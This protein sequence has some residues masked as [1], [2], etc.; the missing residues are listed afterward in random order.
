MSHLLSFARNR[1]HVKRLNHT[2]IEK[3]HGETENDSVHATIEL[4]THQTA[5]TSKQQYIVKEMSAGEFIDL[6]DNGE[7]VIWSKVRQVTAR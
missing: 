2:F 5:R 4:A 6:D 3:G 7:K 1:W